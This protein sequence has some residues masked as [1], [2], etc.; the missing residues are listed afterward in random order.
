[1]HHHPRN[2]S[3]AVG[4]RVNAQEVHRRLACQN[5]RM[6]LLFLMC[7]ASPFEEALHTCRNLEMV[8]EDGEGIAFDA[9]GDIAVV[10]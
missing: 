8:R 4:E 7:F 9:N 10:T 5:K 2:P 6:K 3:V 1:M